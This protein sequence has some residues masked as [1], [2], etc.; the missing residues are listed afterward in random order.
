ML[1]S[2]DSRFVTVIL[3]IIETIWSQFHYLIQVYRLSSGNFEIF[4]HSEFYLILNIQIG[5]VFE[6][7]QN[8]T[9]IR[10]QL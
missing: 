4:Y 9:N 6:I 2:T 3:K 5:S 8:G 7:I 1:F 10:H